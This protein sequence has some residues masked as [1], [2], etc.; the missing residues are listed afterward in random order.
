[1]TSEF[2]IPT[3]PEHAIDQEEMAT[4]SR[5]LRAKYKLPLREVAPLM[6][7]SV[8][9]LSNLE[10]GKDPWTHVSARS[11]IVAVQKLIATKAS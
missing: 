2:D 5:V 10:T 3:K 6:G 1:M 4:R 8:S 7:I 9:K 11:L